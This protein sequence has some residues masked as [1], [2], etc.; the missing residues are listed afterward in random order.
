MKNLDG[1]VVVVTGAARGVGR[2]IA[3]VLAQEGAGVAVAD[4]DLTAATDAVQELE[5]AGRDA[6]AVKVDVADRAS[7]D[8]MVAQVL[9]HY[10][11]LD[12]L[13]ANAGIYPVMALEEMKDTD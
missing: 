3:D 7:V 5:S 4:L 10:G 2:G 12:I 6:V 9:R 8:A 1:R 13:A 11:R